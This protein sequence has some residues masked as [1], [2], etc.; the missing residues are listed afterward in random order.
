VVEGSTASR[1]RSSG[2]GRRLWRRQQGLETYAAHRILVTHPPLPAIHLLPAIH[3]LLDV[4]LAMDF[5]LL[6]AIE[7]HILRAIQLLPFLFAIHLRLLPV[8]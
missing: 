5:D 7:L 6:P 1:A 4:L 8:I 2:D 3:V